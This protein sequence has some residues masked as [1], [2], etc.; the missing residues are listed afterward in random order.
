MLIHQ[1]M[2]PI[3][4]VGLLKHF[5]AMLLFGLQAQHYEENSPTIAQHRRRHHCCQEMDLLP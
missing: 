4:Q 5:E 3:Q 2:Q 1:T